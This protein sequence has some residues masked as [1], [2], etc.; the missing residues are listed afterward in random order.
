M[1][2]GS[3]VASKF[4]GGFTL[5][6]TDNFFVLSNYNTDPSLYLNY[7]NDYHIY[8]QSDK[9]E[10]SK[11][12][13]RKYSKISFVENSGHS[14]TNY[15]RF[16][17][18]HYDDLPSHMMLTKANMIGRHISQEYFDRVYDNKFYTSL[19]DDRSWVDKRGVAYQLYDGAFLEI[20]NSWYASAKPHKY[21]RT[22]NELLSFVFKDPIIPQ[23]LL[24]SPGACY[25]VSKDQVLKYPKA[26]YENLKYLVS[27]A[28]F[29]SEAYHVERMLNVIFMANYE[30]QSYMRDTVFFQEELQ[31]YE[32]LQIVADKQKTVI[33]RLFER[34]NDL[35]TARYNSFLYRM[36][37]G[38]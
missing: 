38:K 10:I 25:I 24:F 34:I 28:Y 36:M 14:I 20:N 2:S 15:F 21:F 23:W 29:P 31:K 27:S 12:L 30:I 26:F 7:C 6:K 16:I 13:K 1:I 8:D 9:A 18:D 4:I 5:K 22:Y 37:I 35:I 33:I 32:K 3:I 11:D 19:Y 17:I